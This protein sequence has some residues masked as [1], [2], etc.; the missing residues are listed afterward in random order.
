MNVVFAKNAAMAC[1]LCVNIE[2]LHY[3]ACKK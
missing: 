3:V 2:Y 1:L